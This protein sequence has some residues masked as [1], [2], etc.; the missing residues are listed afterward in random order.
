MIGALLPAC[1]R[2]PEYRRENDNREQEEYAEDLEKD[3]AADGAEG[4]EKASQ[5]TGYA[6]G[7]L[8]GGTTA[9]GG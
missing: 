8:P 2:T 4:F 9:R 1:S 3:F 5:P 7:G 6:A